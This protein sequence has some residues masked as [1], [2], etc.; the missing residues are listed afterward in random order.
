MCMH[1]H[2]ACLAQ[3]PNSD[4]IISGIW[5]IAMEWDN[6]FLRKEWDKF[7]GNKFASCTVLQYLLARS[8]NFEIMCWICSKFSPHHFWPTSDEAKRR[9]PAVRYIYPVLGFPLLLK[10]PYGVVTRLLKIV[11]SVCWLAPV[12]FTFRIGR[13]FHVKSCVSLWFDFAFFLV[14]SSSFTTLW[15]LIV[16][17]IIILHNSKSQ[18]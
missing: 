14:W 6:F 7:K 15:T 16:L 12:V 10:P 17:S 3:I 2:D 11:R 18:I 1:L 5:L 9:P 4:K 13:V 8:T